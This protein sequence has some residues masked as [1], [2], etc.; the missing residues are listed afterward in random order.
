MKKIN[1]FFII[2][3][4]LL[5]CLQ[6][7]AQALQLGIDPTQEGASKTLYCTHFPVETVTSDTL[8]LE[9]DKTVGDTMDDEVKHYGVN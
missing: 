7:R 3:T 8:N 5:S 9:L 4:F 2:L 1:L 6:I